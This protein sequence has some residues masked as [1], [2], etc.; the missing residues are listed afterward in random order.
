MKKNHIYI[1]SFVALTIISCSKELEVTQ[2]EDSTPQPLRISAFICDT[3]EE[4]KTEY[5]ETLSAFTFAWKADDIISVQ[6]YE[7]NDPLKPNQ[8]KFKAESDGAES[9][10]VQD[11]STYDL[12]TSHDVD[13]FSNK[14]FT[15]GDYA[16]YPKEG[17]GVNSW[18]LN[19]SHST[20]KVD[21]TNSSNY[22]KSNPSSVI[23]LIG[24]KQSG[25]GTPEVE[26]KFRTATGVLKMHFEN[27]P[28]YA[29]KL[30]ITSKSAEDV[31][32]GTWTF[33]E[34]C[35]TNGLT[36]ATATS[37][38]HYKE[39]YF[40]EGLDSGSIDVYIPVPVGTINGFTLD[41]Y[42]GET[43]VYTKSTSKVIS[44]AR[45]ET[46]VI[47]ELTI[48]EWMSLGTG[49][50]KDNKVFTKESWPSFVDVEV[51]ASSSTKGK[52]R[53]VD[54]YAALYA[55]KSMEKPASTSSYFEFTV[56]DKG[57]TVIWGGGNGNTCLSSI[58]SNQIAFGY[59]APG[60]TDLKIYTGQTGNAVFFVHPNYSTSNDAVSGQYTAT[61]NHVRNRVI[62][63]QSSG[64]PAFV[65]LCPKYDG[66]GNAPSENDAVLITFPGC[67]SFSGLD[68]VGISS[69]HALHDNNGE[70]SWGDSGE[71][72]LAD[73]DVNNFW[74]TPNIK[75]L[76]NGETIDLVLVSAV[77]KYAINILTRSNANGTPAQIKL[78]AK[79][80]EEDAWTLLSTT[81]FS[82]SESDARYWLSIPNVGGSTS[83]K[84]FRISI[85]SVYISGN[86]YDL[87]SNLSGL[88]AA[89]SEIEVYGK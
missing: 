87:S 71:A 3:D 54:P 24:K 56:V 73:F 32:A 17:K 42:A 12:T 8:I 13:G 57:T 44:F 1:G 79:V 29:T 76:E 30:K 48:P 84:Y 43:I 36:M 34:A 63:Y 21:L 37:P 62:A 27:F 4:S 16:F 14:N 20:N 81:D 51:Q 68:K 83:Y 38:S 55:A 9:S 53:L 50:F 66:G 67:G 2:Q 82:T 80:N 47:P 18:R 46:V 60:S 77:S 88:Y 74:H 23:P 7:G 25:D 89:L 75:Q 52:Y 70:N 59:Y 5:T 78:S 26:Y 61:N 6:L 31:L 40:S 33:S 22:I 72:A 85:M 86:K 58:T 49:Q 64:L 11:G 15:L 45:A 39:V 35:Y 28:L 10:F 41:I 65:R 69:V 19:Y